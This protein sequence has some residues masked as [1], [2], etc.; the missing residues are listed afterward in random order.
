MGIDAV[1]FGFRHLGHAAGDDRLAIGFQAVLAIN[2]FDIGGVK[3]FLAAVIQLTIERTR[4]HH[5]LGQQAFERLVTI[6][7]SQVTHDLVVKA[8]VQQVQNGVLDAANV[9]IHGQPILGALVQHGTGI[10]AG[11]TG[12]IPTGLHKGVK[13]VGVALCRLS[14]AIQGGNEFLVLFQRTARTV[15]FGVFRQNHRQLIL[16][17]CLDRAVGLVDRRNRAAPVT[18][19]AN[20]PIAQAVIGCHFAFGFVC[21][22]LGDRVK[23]LF[24]VQP[25]ELV[26]IDQTA[27]FCGPGSL[28]NVVL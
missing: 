18:L 16:G 6:D 2:F 1:V 3:P 13:G 12:K 22:G 20:A 27:S 10:G 9:Q 17:H 26:R 4:Q 15:E 28:R 23:R 5:A 7:Q 21:Q 14:L 25:I 19:T 8:R 24:E 11:I